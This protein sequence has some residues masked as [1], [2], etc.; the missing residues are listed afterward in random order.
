MTH[1]RDLAQAAGLTLAW[2]DYRGERREVGD[3]TLRAALNA[4]GY[5]A[6]SESEI[7]E[8]FRCAPRHAIGSGPALSDDGLRACPHCCRPTSPITRSRSC[9][10]RPASVA[11]CGWRP[12]P[13]A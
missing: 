10:W 1:L 7:G 11:R 9:G 8:S 6:G 2:T 5:A 4:I 3:D 13:A 12:V